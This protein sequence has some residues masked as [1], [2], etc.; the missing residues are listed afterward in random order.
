VE[1]NGSNKT[2]GILVLH[3]ASI[4]STFLFLAHVRA[5]TVQ[6]LPQNW[7]E[8]GFIGFYEKLAHQSNI[9]GRPAKY[10]DVLQ[11]NRPRL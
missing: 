10:Y 4:Q 1:S 5:R 9:L 3:R 7:I 2:A 6:Q 11:M 8:L